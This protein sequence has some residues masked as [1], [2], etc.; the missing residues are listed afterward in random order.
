MNK[1]IDILWRCLWIFDW[2]GETFESKPTVQEAEWQRAIQTILAFRSPH[3]HP[4][5]PPVIMVPK[6]DRHPWRSITFVGTLPTH[7]WRNA[8][9]LFISSR[10]ATRRRYMN[11]NQAHRYKGGMSAASHVWFPWRSEWPCVRMGLGKSVPSG[12]DPLHLYL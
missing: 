11:F 12:W 7:F 3:H 9:C 8:L 10:I 5:N 6:C 1:Y 2:G 4:L